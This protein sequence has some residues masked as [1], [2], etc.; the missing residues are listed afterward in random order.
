M[1]AKA[2][3]V[4]YDEKTQAH[5]HAVTSSALRATFVP[6][7]VSAFTSFGVS[8]SI[9]SVDGRWWIIY[10]IDNVIPFEIEHDKKPDRTKYNGRSLAAVR[11]SRRPLLG[12]YKSTSDFFVPIMV[13]SKIV[14]S[15][16][17][18]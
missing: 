10:S 14:A 6:V 17:V 12:S 8:A 18:G 13:E 16:V 1:V 4:L 9:A 5:R 3:S 15:L 11:E 2:W 7:V